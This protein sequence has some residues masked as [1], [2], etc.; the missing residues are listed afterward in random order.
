MDLPQVQEGVKGKR[1][2]V[3]RDVSDE[4]GVWTHAVWGSWCLDSASQENRRDSDHTTVFPLDHLALSPP[5]LVTKAHWPS[6]SWVATYTQPHRR[7]YIQVPNP[8]TSTEG[9]EVGQQPA[10]FF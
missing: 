3:E 5:D 4:E 8:L 2:A 6:S 7:L 10:P 1:K 9:K